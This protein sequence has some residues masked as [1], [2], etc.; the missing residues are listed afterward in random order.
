MKI[1]T[2]KGDVFVERLE[3]GS[4]VLTCDN[5]KPSQVISTEDRIKE[6]LFHSFRVRLR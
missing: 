4:F 2:T 6:I 3:D 5:V 1:K